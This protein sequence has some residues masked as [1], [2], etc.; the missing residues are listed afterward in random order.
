MVEY[1]VKVLARS[2]KLKAVAILATAA[3]GLMAVSSPALAQDA[4]PT[5]ESVATSAMAGNKVFFPGN[6]GKAHTVTQDAKS[7]M[8]DGERL[9]VWSGEFH[10][11]RLPGTDDWRDMFQKMRA[12]GFNAVSLYFFWGLHSTEPGKFDFT[13]I[14]DIGLLLTMAEEEGLYVIARPGPYINAE[15]SMGGLPAYLSKNGAGSL[16]STDPEALRE[17]LSWIDAFNKIAKTHQ[18]TDGGGSIVTYQ[19]ENEMLNEGGDRPA[20]MRALVTKIK[21]DGITV[22]VF[23]NDYSTNGA[24]VPGS[25]TAGGNVGLDYYAFDNYPFGFTCSNGRGQIPDMESQLRALT[26]TSPGFIAEGQG[27]A[28]TPWGASFNPDRCAEFIDPAFTRQYG[29]NNL[30]NGINMFNYYMQYGGTNWGW[31]GSPSSGFTSYDYGAPIN[32]DR[33]LTPKAAVQK[34]LGYF[35]KDFGPISSMVPQAGAPVTVDGGNGTIKSYQRIATEDLAADSVTGNGSRFLGFRQSDS[36][37]TAELKYSFPLTLAPKKDVVEASY[38]NDDRDTDAITYTGTWGKSNGED[39]AAGN[40]KGTETFSDRTGDSVEY[41]FS[42]KGIRVISAQ[43]TNHGYGDVYID[44]VKVGQTNT[45]RGQ[46][47]S[48]QYVAFQKDGLDP[49][50][51]HTI[52]IVVTGQKD[53]GSSGTFVSIDAFDV[54]ARVDQGSMVKFDDVDAAIRYSESGGV[55]QWEHA[56][57][58][59]YT[60]SDYKGTE[61]FS[62][63]KDAFYEYT[64][65]AAKVRLIS[66]RADNHAKADVF[67]DGVKAGQ[68]NTFLDGHTGEAGFLAFEK[69]GLDPAVEHTIKVVNTGVKGDPAATGTFVSVDAIETFAPPTTTPEVP[70]NGITFDRIPQKAG[71]F[72]SMHGRDA[73]MVIADY[74]F[75]GQKLMYSTS[76]LFTKMPV[77]NGTLLVLNGAKNDA[78]ETVLKYASE[79]V[80]TTLGGTPVESVWDAATK[81]LRLNYVHGNGTAVKITSGGAPELRIVTTDRTATALQWTI[82]GIVKSAPTNKTVMVTGVD[83]LRSAEFDADTVKLAGDTKAARTINIYVPAGITKASW[84][85]QALTTTPGANG[86]LVANLVGPAPAVLPAL[87]NWKVSGENPESAVAFDDSTWL[88]ATAT[89]AAN[90]R[91]GPGPN[92]GKVLDTAYYG[93]YEGDTWYR[94]HFKASSAAA[95]IQLRGQGG[96]AANMLVWV[97]GTFVGA[98]AANGTMQTLQVP[99]GVIKNGQDTLVSAVVRNHGQHL[100]W[101]D[102][103][104]SRENRGLFD[105][106]LPNSGAVTWKIQGSKDKA[107]PVDTARTMYN[108]GGLYGERAGWYLPGYPDAQW[109]DASNF[110]PA[111]AG[112]TWYRTSFALAI[113][114][115]TDTAVGLKVN[116]AKFENG[117][118]SYA[119]AVIYVNGWN[120]GTW[121]GNVGPQSTFTIPSGFLNKNGNNT[122]AIALTTERDGEGPDS[123]TLLDRGTSLG[124]VPTTLN[125]AA[126]YVPAVI[127]AGVNVPEGDAG[128]RV[129]V[130][131]TVTLP[132]IGDGALSTAVVDFGDGGKVTVPVTD[133]KYSATHDY[134]KDGAYTASVTV[135]DAVSGAVL[136]TKNTAVTVG[137]AVPTEPAAPPVE[138]SVTSRCIAGKAILTVRA[139][140]THN[141][142]TTINISTVFGGKTFTPVAPGKNSTHAFTTRV[143]ELPSGQLTVQSSTIADGAP[144]TTTVTVPYEALSCSS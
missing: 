62:D 121:V 113:P 67:I 42:G 135:K 47:A 103:G 75:D 19:A 74:A 141:A 90:T 40:H 100:D 72:L 36:N 66:P 1:P 10:Y 56:K 107:T 81:T 129:S 80:V 139:L 133:G 124:G 13:G 125:T 7:F 8:V 73:Q 39:W 2:R 134:A 20:F 44:G 28:Y 97:N 31:T 27:G 24:Y 84:N 126:N 109:A 29:V 14:K 86:Q 65:K 70:A 54:I 119:R 111:K 6:D 112:V 76:E 69:Q 37:S 45:Y 98:A 38:T 55:S 83:L 48:F 132:A 106:V 4:A 22:P 50:V 140:N 92:Q 127:T 142:A 95:S 131:G 77:A 128:T 94:A 35:Q 110:K 79:P 144:K 108:T 78:G 23:H 30:N 137:E 9:N 15:V 91:Q 64:F 71:T 52:K 58:K 105:A 122:L 123:F 115:G 26:T 57:D 16:R 33:Q 82:D 88:V 11:W 85:G 46:N 143:A 34:E 43:S 102:D 120:T 51:E 89:T 60:V 61:T 87:G 93:F 41:R 114:A 117:R 96:N 136:G 49:S 99:A 25:G 68:T 59:P 5:S 17:S 3:M 116:D 18:V 138:A 53:A 101:S 104:L 63:I 12:S 118:K 130:S 32:E 21:A